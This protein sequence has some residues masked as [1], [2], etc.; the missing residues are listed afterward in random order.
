MTLRGF[1]LM[2]EKHRS[3]TFVSEV[4][5][6]E[7]LCCDNS[8]LGLTRLADISHLECRHGAT[9]TPPLSPTSLLIKD[10]AINFPSIPCMNRA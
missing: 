4:G 9:L 1:A 2:S 3:P 7:A 8:N 10:G 5:R 6:L